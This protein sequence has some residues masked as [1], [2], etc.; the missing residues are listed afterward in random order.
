MIEDLVLFPKIPDNCSGAESGSNQPGS[1]II[2]HEL[3]GA[4]LPFS[5]Q[6]GAKAASASAIFFLNQPNKTAIL[7]QPM[8]IHWSFTEFSTWV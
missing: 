3:K 8:A 6:A 5:F 4:K 1:F 2:F 7:A